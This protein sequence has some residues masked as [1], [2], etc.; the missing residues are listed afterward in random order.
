METGQALRIQDW[1]ARGD[2]VPR[3]QLDFLP[4]PGNGP[5][6]SASIVIGY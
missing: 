4:D 3:F 5:R 2:F 6:N 1:H